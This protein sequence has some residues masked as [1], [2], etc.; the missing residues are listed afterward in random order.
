MESPQWAGDRARS[1][2]PPHDGAAESERYV[3]SHSTQRLRFPLAAAPTPA[4]NMLYLTSSAGARLAKSGRCTTA[5]MLALTN[6]KQ[7]CSSSGEL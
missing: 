4:Q 1:P 5:A 3:A 7:L 2:A 6:L